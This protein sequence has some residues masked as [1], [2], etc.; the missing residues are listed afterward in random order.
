MNLPIPRFS[1]ESRE[2]VDGIRQVFWLML[3]RG[4]FPSAGADSGTEEAGNSAAGITGAGHF[5][6]TGIAPDLHRTSL[7]MTQG[8]NPI[9]RE[10]R[11]FWLMIETF[12]F[13]WV[14]AGLRSFA[15]YGN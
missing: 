6:A 3:H 13:G 14:A 10:D 15:G 8:V 4:T 11:F 5:T 1:P 12:A 7:L 9:G 2:C